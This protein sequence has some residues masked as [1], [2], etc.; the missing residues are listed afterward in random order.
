VQNLA[1]ASIFVLTWLMIASRRLDW[2]PLGRP[3]GALLGAVS[4]VAVSALTPK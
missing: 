1:V 2:L 4:M 3:A